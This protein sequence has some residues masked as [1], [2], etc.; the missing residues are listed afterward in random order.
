VYDV[1]EPR[2]LEK[3][4]QAPAGTVQLEPTPAPRRRDLQSR[5]R[6]DGI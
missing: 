4:G 3:L 5:Q 2:E 6:V 1:A